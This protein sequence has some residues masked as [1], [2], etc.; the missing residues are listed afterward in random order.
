MNIAHA[1]E[2]IDKLCVQCL[3]CPN[4]LAVKNRLKET[5]DGLLRE[6]FEWVLQDP[7]YLR[8]RS[9]KDVCL[10]WIKGGAGQ[11][12]TMMSIGLI[13]ELCQE[14]KRR[15]SVVVTYFFC[16]NA[17]NELNTLESLIKGLILRLVNQRVELKE[18]LR[19]RWD[20]KNG[21]FDEDITSWRTLWN[22]LLEML[23]RCGSGPSKTYI[24]VDALDECQDRG[25]T[26]FL[27]LIVRHGLDRP[28]KIK[29]LLTSRPLKA[30]E[31]ALL[32]RCDQLQL[33]LDLNQQHISQS[34]QNYISFKV[35]ELSQ[36]NTRKYGKA[37]IRKV[38]NDLSA[39]TGGTF[40]WVSLVC[41]RLEGVHPD[42]VL[43]MIQD[44]PPG[45]HPFYE[46]ILHQ[47]NTGDT[48]IVRQHMRLLKVMML[49]FRPL[50]VE[51][52]PNLIDLASG[53]DR[54]A[55]KELVDRCAS[56]VKMRDHNL[57]F[58][59][60]SARD[61]LARGTGL[62][63]LESYETRRFGHYDIVLRCL[64][65]LSEH[66]RVNLM[67]LPRPNSTQESWLSQKDKGKMNRLSSLAYA[68]TFWVRHLQNAPETTLAEEGPVAAFLQEKLLE[69]LECLSLLDRL[70]GA[71]VSLQQLVV[72]R[73]KVSV[74]YICTLAIFWVQHLKHL[75]LMFYER[76][77]PQS[78]HWLRM[79]FAY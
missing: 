6:S 47:L 42:N 38:K 51:E 79:H 64:N 23:D 40:L 34:V 39:K 25:M 21:R 24:V 50:K 4:S 30:A 37:L 20:S 77:I 10:L 62:A 57:E 27:K 56:F 55:I 8:W 17:D 54:A 36:Q 18:S 19:R 13:E 2:D 35:N 11:G 58:V 45:L 44:L 12:K 5:K 1:T 31:S 7:N 60:Q 16:Q 70:P 78:L 15:H 49:A 59:H 76:E 32:L 14:E 43:A 68:A 29:W 66:L 65:Q 61:Y 22:I 73:P 52:L 33:S 75:F 71:L 28:S 69:W 41:K 74:E 48:E 9:G 67:D 53:D 63:I 3:R 72:E 26:D 46:R